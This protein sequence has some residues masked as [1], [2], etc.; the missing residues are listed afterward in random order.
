M[1]SFEI[2]SLFTYGLSRIIP[3]KKNRWIFG[4][5][6]GNS[7]SDNTKALYDY[8]KT[9]HPEIERVWVATDPSKVDLPGCTVVKRNSLSSLKYILTAK[10]A[11]MNQGFGDF[12]AYN[13]LGG[14]YKVQL[15]HGVAWKKIG[16]DAI[17]NL[18]GL[19]EKVFQLINHYDLYIAPSKI[20]GESIK[21]AFQTNES[22]IL[23]VGQPRNEV[24]FS[25]SFRS[26]SKKHI[27]DTIGISNKK[28]IV[29]MPTFRDKTS[30][31]FSFQQL[32]RNP[33]FKELANKY[34]FVI[35]EKLHYKNRQ[36]QENMSS[37][38]LVFG[39]P[40]ID[41]TTLLGAADVL[42]TD[43]SSCF[44]DYLIIDNPIIHYAY[45]YEYYK[46]QDRGLYYDI[47]EVAAGT[48]AENEND[49]LTAIEKNFEADPG[50]TRRHIVREK[51]LSYE[52]KSNCE[53][54]FNAIQER[55]AM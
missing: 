51:Y 24:L 20:Y 26:L 3:K 37:E 6:F 40:S 46:K 22:R 10:V 16:R 43:Y 49:L 33:R 9:N 47:A 52:S 55:V 1:Q 35:V 45:D 44:F 30:A 53:A 17:P 14:V 23:Y 12:A 8:V 7:V 38:K 18:K 11:V 42:I 28:I 31:V 25:E 19:Y 50:K 5:W 27:E 21:T 32:E 54:V 29:Y 4:A 36:M 13:F 41:A 39:I 15:W 34:G 48:V 2:I